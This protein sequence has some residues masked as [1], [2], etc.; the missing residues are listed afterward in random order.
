M[1]DRVCQL[2]GGLTLVA[3]AQATLKVRTCTRNKIAHEHRLLPWAWRYP[4]IGVEARL[5]Q[6]LGVG[7][8]RLCENLPGRPRL[9]D[10]ALVHD[11]DA[12]GYLLGRGQVVRYEEV[13][14]SELL[15]E[16]LELVD[17]CGPYCQV[18]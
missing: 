5:A 2:G 8:Q 3:R 15:L 18:E 10:A 14:H 6:C 13:A 9:D 12:I 16:L 11:D 17:D 1:L 4:G 7:M